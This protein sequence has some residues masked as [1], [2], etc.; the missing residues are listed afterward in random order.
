MNDSLEVF[1]GYEV[2]ETDIPACDQLSEMEIELG[3]ECREDVDTIEEGTRD[4]VLEK[5]LSK[6]WT[7]AKV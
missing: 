6:L 2:T 5:F 4:L 3:E 1:V 7:S